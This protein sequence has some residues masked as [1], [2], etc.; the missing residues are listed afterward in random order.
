MISFV[1]PAFC[2]ERRLPGSMARLGEFLQ[3]LG[4]EYEVIWVVDPG[5]DGTFEVLERAAKLN[6]GWRVL[7]LEKHLGKGA[8]VRAGILA[9]RG[10]VCFYFDAD[11]STGLEAVER[12]L[13][14]FE[15]DK[16]V[17]IVAADRTL[18]G[19]VIAERQGFLRRVSGRI[20]RWWTGVLFGLPVRDTQCGFKGIRGEVARVLFAEMRVDEFAFDVELLLLA[21]ERGLEVRALPVRWAND[22]HSS[23][24]WSR[25][26]WR[27]WGDVWRLRGR[28]RKK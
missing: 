3:G 9:S 2:E 23:V 11:L 13:A 5:G 16:G 10:D 26:G 14:V 27:L 15:E 18:A 6:A 4:T 12:A 22:R 8:A 20:F 28:F 19:S 7:R 1:I 25:D 24:R 21:R 17:A